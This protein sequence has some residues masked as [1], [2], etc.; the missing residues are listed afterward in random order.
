MSKDRNIHNTSGHGP[1]IGQFASKGFSVFLVL[2]LSALL[3]T[4]VFASPQKSQKNKQKEKK[5]KKMEPLKTGDK[6]PDF[7]LPDQD[8]KKVTLSELRGKK[9]L[10]YF[11]PRA[12]TPGCTKQACSIRDSAD[13]LKEHGVIPLGISPDKPKAQKKFDEKYS[14]GFRLLCDPNHSAAADYRV[15]VER[16]KGD[17]KRMGIMRSSFLIDEKGRIIEAWY[18]VKPQQTVPNALKALEKKDKS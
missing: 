11:Y 4:D 2:W 6:A 18:G 10:V 16:G 17:K 15:W 8:N 7:S 9:V 5:E 13:E 1:L 3:V 14:L 12:D